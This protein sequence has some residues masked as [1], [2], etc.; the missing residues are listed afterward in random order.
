MAF[1][2][3]GKTYLR[4]DFDFD[5][6]KQ[7]LLEKPPLDKWVNNDKADEEIKKIIEKEKEDLRERLD[8]RA[9]YKVKKRDD[10]DI[11]DYSPPK[12]LINS[13]LLC[14]GLVTLGENI[15]KTSK[16]KEIGLKGLII[17]TTEN[18]MLEEVIKKVGSQ[19][20]KTANEENLNTTRLLQPGS[21]KNDWETPNQEFIIKNIDSSKIGVKLTSNYLLKP[22]KSLSFVI[23]V[24]KNIENVESIFS[25]KGCQRYDCP[26]RKE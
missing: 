4:S 26:Y 2:K 7:K 3:T 1:L 12:K 16:D 22:I 8:P 15:Y 10:T 21:G 17:D 5:L 25:C 6:N 14:I 18:I 11:E 19:I 24:D 9:I 13:N 23:G 20:K